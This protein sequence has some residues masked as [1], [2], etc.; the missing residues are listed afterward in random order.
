MTNRTEMRAELST[1]LRRARGYALMTQ[2]QLADAIG[3]SRRAVAG[4]EADENE[5]PITVVLA[6]L[7][8]CDRPV[9]D[10]VTLC[11]PWDLNPEP[12]DYWSVAEW[13]LAATA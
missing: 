4:Y 9:S 12:A 2:Q 7:A 10:L 6:W 13:A 5:P 11:A 8:A 1:M 3:I